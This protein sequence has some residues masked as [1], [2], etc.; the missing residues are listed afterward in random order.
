MRPD[1]QDSDGSLSNMTEKQHM[2]FGKGVFILCVLVAR[3][4]SSGVD[5]NIDKEK[6]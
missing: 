5:T 6:H 2:Q 1:K 3:E 4:G